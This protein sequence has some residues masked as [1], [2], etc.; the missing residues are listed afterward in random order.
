MSRGDA[1]MGS[2]DSCPGCD[3][4]SEEDRS[5]RSRYPTIYLGVQLCRARPR[6][7]GG[8]CCAALQEFR[9]CHPLFGE[10]QN[11]VGPIVLAAGIQHDAAVSDN[12]RETRGVGGNC[13]GSS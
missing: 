6:E 3:R 4:S 1:V 9:S 7:R 11:A 10:R 12:L 8:S 5:T 13:N 2:A